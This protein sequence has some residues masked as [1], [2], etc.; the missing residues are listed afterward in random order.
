[1]GSE[2]FVK[3]LA[4]K[5]KAAETLPEIPRRQQLAARP[6]LKRL[7]PEEGFK[8]KAARDKA[9]HHA[10]RHHGYTLSEIGRRLDLHY[11]TISKVVNRDE[12]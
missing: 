4:S 1:L 10:H 3:K 2:A 11:T 7:F 6:G 8:D 9:I 5:L 12:A